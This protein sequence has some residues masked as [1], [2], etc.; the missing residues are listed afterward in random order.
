MP[1]FFWFD[2]SLEARTEISEIFS[3]LFWDKRLLYKDILKLSDL[4]I[5]CQQP[6]LHLRI[7]INSRRYKLVLFWQTKFRCS[8]WVFLFHYYCMILP[9]F[10]R[11]SQTISAYILCNSYA[12]Y[13]FQSCFS[14][15]QI[16]FQVLCIGILKGQII[17]EQYCGVLNF[18]KKQWYH[19]KDF[20]P[21]L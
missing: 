6:I 5:S 4:K 19:C 12:Y 8:I 3:L 21:R 15:F 20:C 16:L 17:S 13:F 1:L 7:L 2:L 10:L 11:N 9:I 18:P 14:K